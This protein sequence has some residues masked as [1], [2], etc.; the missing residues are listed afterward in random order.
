MNMESV[1]EIVTDFSNLY[2]AMMH[3]TNG[4]KWKAGVIQYLQN[5]LVNTWK[6]QQEVRSGEYRIGKKT[7]F[8]IYEPKLR[9]VVALKFRDRQIEQSLL[10]NYLYREIT[11]HFIYDN[12]AC[13]KGKGT[14]LAVKRL[15]V[16]MIKAYR[17][18]GNNYYIAQFDIRH[19]FGSTLH[20]VAKRAIKKRVRDDW[21]VNMVNMLIDSSSGDRGIDL[22]SDIAQFIELSVLDGMDHYIKEHLHEKFYLRYMD[23][24]LIIGND[25]SRLQHDRDVIAKGLHG[26]GLELHP[27]KTHITLVGYGIKWQGYRYRQTETGK[28]IM[29][30]DKAKIY[31]ERR[32]LKRMMRQVEAGTL[33]IETANHSLESWRSHAQ[34]GNNHKIIEKME[35]FYKSIGGK[36]CSEQCQKKSKN[37]KKK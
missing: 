31:H 11:R 24:F 23:D 27:A 2:D 10:D 16:M 30:L 33:S 5:G 9:D 26:I 34:I 15:K 7:H 17:L 28:I 36:S 3:C 13:Q 4:V 25:K 6:L 12:V 14:K 18:W 19:F 1:K 8:K 22:G 21:A 20:S 37:E 29:T 32:K 35:E